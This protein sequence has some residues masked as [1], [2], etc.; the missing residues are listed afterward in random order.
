M[1]FSKDIRAPGGPSKVNDG[2]VWNTG[3]IVVENGKPQDERRSSHLA[4]V[5]ITMR[6]SNIGWVAYLVMLVTNFAGSAL[7]DSAAE[8]VILTSEVLGEERPLNIVLPAGY[9]AEKTYPVVF[10]LDGN[11]DYLP[12]VA[13][14]MQGAH[15]DLIVVGIE[16]VDRSHD[17]FPDPVPERQNR[18]G[19]GAAF[20]EFLTTEL[21]PFI[22]EKY[23][24]SGYRVLSGQSNSGFFVLYAMLNANK[25]FDAYLA[26]SPM[27]GW[28]WEMI[29]DGSIDLLEGRKSFPRVLFMNRGDEDLSRTTEFLPGYV[30]LLEKI[31]PRDFRWTH[32]VVV[33]GGHVPENSYRKG[34]AFIFGD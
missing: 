10:A 23:A 26:S 22:E 25:V 6:K 33:D 4:E 1:G 24:A 16:N 19:G 12:S 31:A 29:R 18:G 17:M 34:V 20:L 21:V 5:F 27:I 2:Q 30:D 14:R 13:E 11:E 15:P 7:A 9:S 28:D 8:R 32:E 3:F